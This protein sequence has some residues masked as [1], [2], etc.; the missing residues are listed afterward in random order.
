M[1]N[2]P[3]DVSSLIHAARL[4]EPGAVDALLQGY[5]N[6]L[7]ML[8]R[9]WLDSDLR[10]KADPSDLVQET[11]LKAQRRFRQFHGVTEPELAGWL[12]R[13]LARNVVDLVRRFRSEGRQLGR[14]RSL[15]QVLSGS[16]QAVDGLMAASGT[17]PSAAAQRREL[18]VLLAD[19]MADL[20]PEHRE[21]IVLR[22]LRE[23]DWDTVAE[24]MGRGRDAVRMLWTRALRELRPKIEQQL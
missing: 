2:P 8:A 5:A 13:I 15:E 12:R 6:Y 17:S 21:V 14:E 11:M 20:T 1:A 24:T 23:L 7:H 10:A 16:V 22:S 9:T 19:A 18:G 3:Q 4:A